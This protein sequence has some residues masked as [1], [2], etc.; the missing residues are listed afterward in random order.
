MLNCNDKFIYH[1]KAMSYTGH[2]YVLQDMTQNEGQVTSLE[3][4]I[5]LALI[6]VINKI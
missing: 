1:Y 4:K 5:N 2:D 3:S 6:G